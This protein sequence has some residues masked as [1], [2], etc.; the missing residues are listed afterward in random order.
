MKVSKLIPFIFFSIVFISCTE[1][2]SKPEETLSSPKVSKTEDKKADEKS[3]VTNTPSKKTDSSD[4]T[5][6]VLISKKWSI[7]SVNVGHHVGNSYKHKYEQLI[8]E[9]KKHASFEF[10]NDGKYEAVFH[11]N[12][13]ETGSWKLTEDGKNIITQ[14]DDPVVHEPDEIFIE[15]I[16]QDSL[17]LSRHEE[18]DNIITIYFKPFE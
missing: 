10:K 14:N 5:T 17:A 6:Q 1:K 3:K 18:D 2:D 9:A 11:G 12:T 13:I 8:A 16:S 15:Y 4:N 7:D